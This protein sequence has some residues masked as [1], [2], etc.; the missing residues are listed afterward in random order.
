MA[1]TVQEGRAQVPGTTINIDEVVKKAGQSGVEKANVFVLCDAA[2]ID[3]G[4]TVEGDGWVLNYL[5]KFT[6]RI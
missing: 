1:Q 2:E 5:G 3:N 6:C 4:C